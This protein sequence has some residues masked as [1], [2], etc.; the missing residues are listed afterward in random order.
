MAVILVV[1]DD[2]SVRGMVSVLLTAE[3]HRIVT[4]VNGAEAVAVYRSFPS[5]IDLVITDLDM[6]TMDG[7]QEILRIRMTKPDAKFICMTGG[8]PDRC[9]KDVVLMDKPFAIGEFLGAVKKLLAHNGKS[10]HKAK[11]R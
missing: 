6:P 7:V 8:S 11:N 10:E 2:E 4:A 1:D 3:G 9:P 5:Q